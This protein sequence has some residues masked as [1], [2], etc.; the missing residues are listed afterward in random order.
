MNYFMTP[1]VAVSFSLANVLSYG[2]SK[3]DVSGAKAQTEFNGNLNV[4]NNIFD[5]PT[6]GLMYK[7]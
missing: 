5:T 2:T 7:F 6:I 4:F 1:S 3:V